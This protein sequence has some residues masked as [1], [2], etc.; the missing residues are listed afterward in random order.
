MNKV[1]LGF[2]AL[3]LVACDNNKQ[4]S[5]QAFLDSLDN[6]KVQ[7]P[8]VS[9]EVL[10]DIIQ[11]IPSP[12]EISSLI[13]NSGV[14]Y[15]KNV[16]NSTNNL[17]NYNTNYKRALNLGIYGT[18]LGYANI[19]SQNQDA[20]HYL[21]AVRTTA[22]GLSIGQFFDF[23]TIRSLATNSNNLDSLLL[24]TTTNFEKINKHLQEQER[25]N[26]SILILTG[27][28]LEALHLT[29]AVENK[30]PSQTFKERIGEQK[31]IL[32]QLLLLLSFYNQDANIQSLI[33]DLTDLQKQFEKVEVTYTYQESTMKEV[34]GVLMVVDNSTKKINM[35]PED[36]KSIQAAASAIRNK[37]IS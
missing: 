10:G 13:K 8:P 18:D 23:N 27:G 17:S 11:S 36:L 31:V 7:T 26:L 6:A 1:Y 33:A 32:D 16:L 22:D 30:Y 20:L 15:D 29:C 4:P 21:D 2:I 28:W 14:K 34:D 35:T 3:L 19:Y 37:I 25:S 24:I 9:K 12:L 5:E